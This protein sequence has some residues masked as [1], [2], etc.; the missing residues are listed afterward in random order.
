MTR[1]VCVWSCL[2]SVLAPGHECNVGM[3]ELAR[4][5]AKGGALCCSVGSATP[6][7]AQLALIVACQSL[8]W[9][10]RWSCRLT[11]SQLTLEQA[12]N[13]AA[14]RGC[15]RNSLPVSRLH[16]IDLMQSGDV[17]LP[18]DAFMYADASGVVCNVVPVDFP[19]D[20]MRGNNITTAISALQRA[21]PM[22][23]R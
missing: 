12:A 14:R 22:L 9:A 3:K 4:H 5:K 23:S 20:Q 7:V 17:C 10:R 6:S 19:A 16:M 13:R 2:Q 11:S 8:R 15:C 1:P 21:C 18:I